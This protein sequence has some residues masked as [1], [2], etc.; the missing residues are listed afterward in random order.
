[1][2]IDLHTHTNA[3]SWCSRADAEYI[4]RTAKEAGFDGVAITNHYVSDYFDDN[5]YDAWIEAYI[6]EWENCR[7]LGSKY[8]F[9]VFCG[10]EVTMN[11]VD[12]RL[13]VLLYGADEAFLRN[14][15]RLCEKTLEELYGL[16]RQYGYALVQAHPFRY[17]MTIQ[18]AKYLDGVE[19]NCHPG[20]DNGYYED[21][22]ARAKEHALAVTVGCDYHADTKY[23]PLG[24]TI[25]PDSI[26][27]EKDL[28]NYILHVKEF[29][30]QIHEPN[31][32]RIFQKKY[33]R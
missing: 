28:A 6:A 31:D 4:I 33:E 8:D 13:H 1:M 26:Q 2:F 17:G 3:I 10:I 24:G 20:H 18:N 11:A 30:L 21:I 7:N 22:L 27:D 5:T 25:L 23:R 16:C 19:I 12:P 32:Q 29:E 15:P 9:R 14:H